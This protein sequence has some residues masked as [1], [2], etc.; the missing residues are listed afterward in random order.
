[1]YYIYIYIHISYTYMYTTKPEPFLTSTELERLLFSPASRPL[2]PQPKSPCPQQPA[3][4]RPQSGIM[5]RPAKQPRAALSQ[6][7]DTRTHSSQ[8]VSQW[9]SGRCQPRL[10][11]AAKAVSSS[12]AE[13][14]SGSGR[15]G[16][17]STTSD[18][19]SRRRVRRIFCCSLHTSPPSHPSFPFPPSSTTPCS[20]LDRQCGAQPRLSP[21]ARENNCCAGEVH[22][23]PRARQ[24]G[25]PLVLRH[26]EP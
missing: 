15:S 11:T 12:R 24:A 9:R 5:R 14:T 17:S 26:A 22:V 23:R 25:P 3:A 4:T 19:L 18:S 8:H 2:P 21:R 6:E 20:R 1:M 16:K 13:R 10:C 7:R